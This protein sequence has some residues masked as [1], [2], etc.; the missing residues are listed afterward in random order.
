MMSAVAATVQGPLA[1]LTMSPG[2]W[3][4]SY[5][6]VLL[7]APVTAAHHF[8]LGCEGGC[9]VLVF[10]LTLPAGS[11][12]SLVSSQCWW[13]QFSFSHSVARCFHVS[14]FLT[15]SISG[16]FILR[17]LWTLSQYVGNTRFSNIVWIPLTILL[18]VGM[19]E[20][21]VIFSYRSQFCDL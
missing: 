6:P 15:L 16:C 17:L 1:T 4:S 21:R 3:A 19:L 5:C 11:P 12:G 7:P 8:V 10:W 13:P 18:V 2:D 9:V 14:C 20:H